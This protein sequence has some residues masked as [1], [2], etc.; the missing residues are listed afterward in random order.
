MSSFIETIPGEYLAVASS[1]VYAGTLV[2]IR[3]GMVGSTPMAALLIVNSIVAMGGLAGA[4]FRGTLFTV[5]LA[6]F[7]WFALVG[8]LGQG[9]GTLTYYNGIDRMGVGRATAI[10]SSSPLW[11][12]IFAI[13]VLGE[14]PGMAV[15]VGTVAIVGGV[16]LLAVPEDWDGKGG[17]IQSALI[18]PLISSVAY[19]FVPIFA[20]I[21]F[22]FQKSPYLGFGVAFSVGTLTMLM[23]T[24][25]FPTGGR[26]RMNP[27]SFGIF[28]GAGVLNLL[29]AI[30][31][32]IAIVGGK[33]TVVLPISRL[34]PLWVLIL[35]AL[36]LGKLERITARVVT[37]GVL[38]VVGGVLTVAF[39]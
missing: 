39:G 5:A 36:F 4:A 18:Y 32:W 2:S 33:V 24:R 19:A 7:F 17:W 11:G 3:R 35:G 15:L 30:F 10:Q 12:A 28:V 21:A 31:F 14:R 1:L 9:I 16:V 8:L 23:G 29:G 26:I 6:P 37:A 38:V 27:K 20:K 13:L 34:Y 22:S 25:I